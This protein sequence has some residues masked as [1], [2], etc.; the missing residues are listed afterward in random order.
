MVVRAE[1]TADRV[2]LRY[3]ASEQ[4]EA[5]RDQGSVE[6]EVTMP[7]QAALAV[8]VGSGPIDVGNLEG[9]IVLKTG[10]GGIAARDVSGTLDVRAG[11]GAIDVAGARGGLRLHADN[12]AICMTGIEGSIDAETS[13]GGITFRGR[14][15]G[16]SH[17]MSTNDGDI[18]VEL[19]T[20][21]AI[22]IDATASH[23]I[24][25]GGLPLV[26]D[27]EGK[28]WSATLNPPPSAVL[29]LLASAG[30][31]RIRPAS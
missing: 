21:L 19:P 14:P 27:T 5:V 30:R 10:D 13:K 28:Q 17:R 23:G 4:T 31:I 24:D 1:Q 15:V 29:E 6:F 2:V 9:T 8:D 12:G 11:N 20:D 7:M 3:D 22:A 25:A 26:G 16:A 18:D